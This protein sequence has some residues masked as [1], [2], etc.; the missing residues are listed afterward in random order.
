MKLSYEAISK[1][2]ES[3]ADKLYSIYEYK[4]TMYEFLGV[5]KIAG[6]D[7]DKYMVR[8]SPTNYDGPF[9]EFVRDET[10]FFNK[11]KLVSEAELQLSL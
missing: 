4:G 9:I 3:H 6:Q 7:S 10:D 11:F 5:S 2:T 8:Y 1:H